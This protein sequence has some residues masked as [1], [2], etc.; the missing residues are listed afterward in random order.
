MASYWYDVYRKPYEI[1]YCSKCSQKE[2]EIL[3]LKEEIKELKKQL[4]L[5]K[6]IAK[7]DY[8]IE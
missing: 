2:T 6:Q 7:G 4:K 5:I 8:F 3:Y 1:G